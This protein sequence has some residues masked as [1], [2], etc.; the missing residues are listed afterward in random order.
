MMSDTL[1][2]STPAIA[3][4]AKAEDWVSWYNSWDVKTA[5]NK[6]KKDTDTMLTTKV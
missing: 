4:A 1:A 6:P 3:A 2:H 5:K